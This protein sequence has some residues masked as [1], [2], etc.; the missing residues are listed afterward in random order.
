[1]TKKYSIEV[2]IPELKEY[3]ERVVARKDQRGFKPSPTIP[4]KSE[5]GWG[6]EASGY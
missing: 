5:D 6:E 3:F 2:A 1:M 4:L